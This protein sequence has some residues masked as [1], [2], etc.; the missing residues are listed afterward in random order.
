MCK[1]KNENEIFYEDVVGGNLVIKCRKC[2][3]GQYGTGW[4]CQKCPHFAQEYTKQG[5]DYVCTCKAT[6]VAAGDGCISKAD[7]LAFD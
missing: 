4:K 5:D 1:C 6:Y 3:D 2:P 7:D